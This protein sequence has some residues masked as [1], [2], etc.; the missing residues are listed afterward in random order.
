MN[1]KN[2]KIQV[3]FEYLLSLYSINKFRPT[4][5][6]LKF[7]DLIPYT[8]ASIIKSCFIE[9]KYLNIVF[10][11]FGRL[12]IIKDIKQ[13]KF[14]I[15][16]FFNILEKRITKNEYL[17]IEKRLLKKINKKRKKENKKNI[18]KKKNIIKLKELKFSTNLPIFE[19]FKNEKIC[20]AFSLI[21]SQFYIIISQYFYEKKLNFLKINKNFEIESLRLLTTKEKKKS[22]FKILNVL[23]DSIRIA[24]KFVEVSYN[25][26]ISDS[27]DELE[28]FPIK[29]LKNTVS[30]LNKIQ[31]TNN[32]CSQI[33][34]NTKI[35]RH[36]YKIMRFIKNL[37]CISYF[38]DKSYIDENIL[39]F[40]YRNIIFSLFRG[41]VPYLVIRI[42]RLI[43]RLFYGRIKNK[44]KKQTKQRILSNLDIKLKKELFNELKLFYKTN[45]KKIF[46][47][48]VNLLFNEIWKWKKIGF[49]LN[50]FK[51][52][53][54]ESENQNEFKNILF[55]F[56]NKKYEILKKD[57]L[58]YELKLNKTFERNK[59][60][61]FSITNNNSNN[62]NNKRVKIDDIL[63]P[64]YYYKRNKNIRKIKYYN[65]S[66]DTKIYKSRITRYLLIEI[67]KKKNSINI[68]ELDKFIE[69]LNII[70]N[71]MFKLFHSGLN[72]TVDFNDIQS[73]INIFFDYS[74]EYLIARKK[75]LKR[76]QIEEI[77]F[78]NFIGKNTSELY[79]II[80]TYLMESN[81]HSLLI[82]LDR[83][84]LQKKLLIKNPKF[85]IPTFK[86]KR[87]AQI[88]NFLKDQ[89]I[90]LLIDIFFNEILHSYIN[91]L[92]EPK[93][94]INNEE[95]FLKYIL[96]EIKISKM[97][98][99]IKIHVFKYKLN[100]PIFILR[101]LLDDDFKEFSFSKILL[102]HFIKRL[103]T[104][105]NYKDMSLIP[106]FY[107]NIYSF[108][109]SIKLLLS[110]LISEILKEYFIEYIYIENNKFG[111]L[112]DGSCEK[113]N[114][115]GYCIKILK[116][117][118]ELNTN[119]SNFLFIKEIDSNI[120]LNYEI[121]I[122]TLSINLS[123]EIFNKLV[124]NISKLLSATL[125]FNDLIK[126]YNK[127]ILS[128]IYK[129]KLLKFPIKRN[130]FVDS[131]IRKIMESINSKMFSRYPLA[132]FY[133]PPGIGLGLL[134][135]Q[136]HIETILNNDPMDNFL[137]QTNLQLFIKNGKINKEKYY[138]NIIKYLGGIKEIT[139]LT[140]SYG[141]LYEPS[142]LLINK[143][144]DN[145]SRP[146]FRRINK[147]D[148]E[149]YNIKYN[150]KDDCFKGK[151][152]KTKSQIRA[153]SLIPNKYFLLNWLPSLNT[154]NVFIGEK[155]KVLKYIWII[156]KLR[157]LKSIIK[158]IFEPKKRIKEYNSDNLYNLLVKYIK[159]IIEEYFIF[160]NIKYEK[161]E[162][163]IMKPDFI[164]NNE[165]N[166]IKTNLL[167]TI[168]LNDDYNEIYKEF[169]LKDSSDIFS[170][171]HIN[172]I[173]KEIVVINCNNIFNN[174]ILS[175]VFKPKIFNNYIY[176]LIESNIRNLLNIKINKKTDIKSLF[177]NIIKDENSGIVF[178]PKSGV[179]M[180]INTFERFQYFNKENSISINSQIL[181]NNNIENEFFKNI[182]LNNLDKEILKVN[183]SLNPLTSYIPCNSIYSILEFFNYTIPCIINN[184]I[185]TT[186]I[187]TT[188]E[189]FC[190]SILYIQCINN[191]IYYDISFIKIIT[192]KI[193]E[194]YEIKNKKYNN[195]FEFYSIIKKNKKELNE[196]ELL[197]LKQIQKEFNSKFNHLSSYLTEK[198]IL[199]IKEK[200]KIKRKL[201]DF[202]IRN[203]IFNLNILPDY[204][205]EEEK[206]IQV[207]LNGISNKEFFK[208]FFK[209]NVSEVLN[210]YLMDFKKD[211]WYLRD[212]NLL[213]NNNEEINS[214]KIIY[215][216]SILNIILK[217]KKGTYLMK[218]TDKKI[219]FGV[220][221]IGNNYNLLFYKRK[222]NLE[223]I[224]ILITFYE[225]SLI[226]DFQDEN[227][228]F[229]FGEIY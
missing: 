43:Y 113:D 111:I 204:N 137:N 176:E 171:I 178:I 33:S 46:K 34:F 9:Q 175:N 125:S 88:Q 130:Y 99:K 144:T 25:L 51:I 13:E 211:I 54:I 93:I 221:Q 225:N 214:F 38:K 169:H 195:L 57:S 95:N 68:E 197:K 31:L 105:L 116:N 165:N 183:F 177:N 45:N 119:I 228:K 24:K 191:S 157:G 40:T 52:N 223:D 184:T 118:K 32:F 66:K 71:K 80:N 106:F 131:I 208:R 159:N 90:N 70:E 3:P 198:L 36:K 64:I 18:F 136:F 84:L 78:E 22:R 194:I 140:F 19:E 56:I 35:Y 98:P 170:L 20:L 120:I 134:N 102:K 53:I 1:N 126:R 37:K 48:R 39:Y 82:S 182:V 14:E 147:I 75:F 203:L 164:I 150:Q 189:H 209:I 103:D 190:L 224:S 29:F 2:T 115:S 15:R 47:K 7:M 206:E 187:E 81:R 205:I 151:I 148:I 62:S 212:Y 49:N 210:Y 10:D 107:I 77:D 42:N 26:I 216:Y 192:N 74:N 117:I 218:S 108:N 162:S 89:G 85:S 17:K 173:R 4:R 168:T 200:L 6:I 163:K 79:F 92:I 133:G 96:N 207:F 129:Y 50:S 201:N 112:C 110:V 146:F 21:F 124:F 145:Y 122:S 174:E 227:I 155:E 12:C 143:I 61:F 65:L 196:N 167:I 135:I 41:L 104:K 188:W 91:D 142:I 128:F 72:K 121:K 28:I 59:E 132:L 199:K 193:I 181:D 186:N 76:F 27:Y 83:N 141:L 58:K 69:I 156:G 154:S 63:I 219:I 67:N 86:K 23:I 172:L 60:M 217:N 229:N 16:N 180:N 158:K 213:N 226:F 55:K 160:K 97:Y 215:L 222:F 127:L 100:I 152:I 114:K 123:Y 149:T 30:N 109:S 139:K 185:L 220:L 8:T 166:L 202:E 161:L 73:I 5:D 101:N 11:G 44:I 179:I 138:E 87:N 153:L 94:F